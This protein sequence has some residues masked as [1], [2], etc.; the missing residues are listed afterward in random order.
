MAAPTV[1]TPVGVASMA[2]TSITPALPAV[3]FQTG[4]LIVGVGESV[5]DFP[6]AASNG[7][8]H[9]TG[10]PVVQD[11]N[12]R[13]TLIWRRWTAG[14]T[15]HAWGNTGNHAIGAY[16]A[17]RGCKTTGNPWNVAAPGVD[18]TSDN[19]ALWPGHTPG[20]TVDDCLVLEIGAWSDDFA[21][22]ALTNASLTSITER[23]DAV[24]SA[25]NDGA[26]SG[27]CWCCNWRPARSSCAGSWSATPRRSLSRS[28]SPG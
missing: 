28:P 13:L 20:T 3:T 26:R 14:L 24:T 23:I 15:A 21:T 11:T 7:F 6:T 16:I 4:D 1:L 25:G 27:T 2:T 8:A 17:I 18:A 12:T 10:S 5:A 22:G 19:S 9:V